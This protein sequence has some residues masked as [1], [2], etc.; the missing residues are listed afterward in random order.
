MIPNGSD[1][2]HT[3]TV[4]IIVMYAGNGMFLMNALIVLSIIN[5][6]ERLNIVSMMFNL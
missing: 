6:P 4:K 2:F 3:A 1:K 5:I